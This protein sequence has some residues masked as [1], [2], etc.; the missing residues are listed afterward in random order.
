MSRF[1]SVQS[2]RIGS[3]SALIAEADQADQADAEADNKLQ[4]LDTDRAFQEQIIH[5]TDRIERNH[6]AIRG[7]ERDIGQIHEMFR[8]LN[9]LVHEQQGG[10]DNIESNVAATSKTTKTALKDLKQAQQHQ[11]DSRCT[12]S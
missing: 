3:S 9:M 1:Y 6:E 11:K 2:S 4:L 5:H 12:I 10:I 8:D 7:M